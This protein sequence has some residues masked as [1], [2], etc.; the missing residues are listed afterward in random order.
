MKLLDV[1]IGAG[2]SAVSPAWAVVCTVMLVQRNHIQM[3]GSRI[4]KARPLETFEVSIDRVSL[5]T[6]P[7]KGGHVTPKAVSADSLCSQGQRNL[8]YFDRECIGLWHSKGTQ[9]INS[10]SVLLKSHGGV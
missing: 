6:R 10:V 5:R 2:F 8:R 7:W 3:W 4:C 1:R 9:Y